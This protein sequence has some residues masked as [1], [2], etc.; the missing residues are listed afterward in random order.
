MLSLTLFSFYAQV[1][2]DGLAELEELRVRGRNINN[3]RYADDIVM[4]ADLEEK[5]QR[6]VDGLGEEC[7]KYGLSVNKQKTE[8]MGLRKR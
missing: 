1:I 8:V 4:T 7:S 6:L 2:M 5:W 3:I